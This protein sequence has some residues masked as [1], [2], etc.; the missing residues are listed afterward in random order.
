[1]EGA[2][3]YSELFKTGQYGRLY[4]TSGRHARGRTFHIQ[5]LPKY[6]KARPNGDTNMC[7]NSDAVEVYGIIG[8]QPGWTEFYG[9]K[10]EGPWQYDFEQM[11]LKRKDEINKQLQIQA[12]L[13]SKR[14]K[15]TFEK[16]QALLATY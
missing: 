15:E 2:R 3:E 12:E 4:I 5:V 6:E 10:H 11:V 8:G 14:D 9:W 7:L 1:M 13:S 16:E